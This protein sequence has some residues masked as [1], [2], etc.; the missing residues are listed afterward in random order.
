M[1]A[2]DGHGLITCI[3]GFREV[4]FSGLVLRGLGVLGSFELTAVNIASRFGL[5]ILAC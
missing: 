3:Q 1:E 2:P 5:G 4:S